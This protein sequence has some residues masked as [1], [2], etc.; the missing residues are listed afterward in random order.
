MYNQFFGH[1]TCD[2]AAATLV[3][4]VTKRDMKCYALEQQYSDMVIV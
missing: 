4:H 3:G 2:R 1:Q